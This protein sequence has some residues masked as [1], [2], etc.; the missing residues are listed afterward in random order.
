MTGLLLLLDLMLLIKRVSVAVPAEDEVALVANI[1]VPTS[2]SV[3]GL[4]TI[5]SVATGENNSQ[6]SG[7][8]SG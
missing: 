7:S 8:A 2:N 1:A 3:L 5:S 6:Q 4:G